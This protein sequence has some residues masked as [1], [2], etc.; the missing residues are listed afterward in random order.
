DGF[1][2]RWSDSPIETTSFAL[3]ALS[4]IEPKSALVEASMNWLVKNRRGAQWS[5][6]RDTAIALLA[7]TS[8]LK[9]SGELSS[10]MEYALH[11]N[12]KEIARRRITTEDVLAAPSRFFVD[13]DLLREANEIRLER[14]SGEGPLY[15]S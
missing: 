3:M 6:T 9:S 1:W 12:G 2:W 5:N 10:G 4:A 15:F 11:V 7:L 8:Y 14:L 13:A